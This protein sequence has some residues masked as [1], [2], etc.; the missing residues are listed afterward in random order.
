[1]ENL[2]LGADGTPSR[3]DHA[4]HSYLRG[5]A[6]AGGFLG[7]RSQAGRER[8]GPPL[9]ALPGE[10]VALWPLGVPPESTRTPGAPAWASP[11]RRG[12]WVEVSRACRVTPMCLVG[13]NSGR[14]GLQDVGAEGPPREAG[15][16]VPGAIGG[17]L[18]RGP[19]CVHQGLWPQ[20]PGPRRACLQ[21]TDGLCRQGTHPNCC[22]HS[23]SG[24]GLHGL[25]VFQLPHAGLCFCGKEQNIWQ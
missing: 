14:Q 6:H 5:V 22:G 10:G 4:G 7:R 9:L 17:V 1:M 13:P 11:Q 21:G 2:G 19:D 18:G 20:A 24:S 16:Q 12:R 3:P 25:I 15:R 8:G 23:D